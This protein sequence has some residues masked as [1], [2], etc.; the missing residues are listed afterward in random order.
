[1]K[2]NLL[3]AVS[4]IA[5]GAAFGIGTLGAA[6]ASLVCTSAGTEGNT[7]GSYSCTS[8]AS[9]GFRTTDFNN[10][11]L[12]LSKWVNDASAGF[13]ETLKSVTYQGL[14]GWIST[15]TLN[16][17]SNTSETFS[18]Q[19]SEHYTF[20]PNGGAPSNFL[21]PSLTAS[22]ATPAVA[23]TLAS[24]GASGIF[25]QTLSL[26]SG[27]VTLTSGLAAYM[28]GGTFQALASTLTGSTFFGGGGNIQTHLTTTA[29]P[30]ILV[31]YNFTTSQ[32]P[33]PPSPT[34]EPASLALLGAG[35]AGLGAV[36]RR[37]KK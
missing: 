23:Y 21:S 28:G 27:I 11:I 18:F 14:G 20:Q 3:G 26:A 2:H 24:S 9:L 31:T 10:S 15:G 8:T 12:T 36:R 17:T 5:L 33:P 19:E 30:E 25:S 37:R 32:P 34:P 4:T 1:M 16:N 6:N 29:D 35:L 13:T 22:A 7:V